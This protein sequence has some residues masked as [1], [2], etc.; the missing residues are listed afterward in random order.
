LKLEESPEEEIA[1]VR[2]KRPHVV[3]LG[4]GA[5]RAAFPRGERNGKHL[6]VMADFLE[7]PQF[8]EVLT[9]AGISHAGRNFEELYFRIDR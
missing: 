5:S 6:R 1:D 3:L 8:A 4:A 7:M 9:S 2:T